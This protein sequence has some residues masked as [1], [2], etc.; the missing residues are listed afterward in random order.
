MKNEKIHFSKLK[1]HMAQSIHG[2]GLTTRVISF[3]KLSIEIA[4]VFPQ[5]DS[6]KLKFNDFTQHIP[7]TYI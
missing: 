6:N 2:F 1:I 4:R 3:I 7:I 5:Q